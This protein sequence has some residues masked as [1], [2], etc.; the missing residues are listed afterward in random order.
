MSYFHEDNPWIF[1]L[2]YE[3]ICQALCIEEISRK[4][5]LLDEL[6]YTNM[7]QGQSG[8]CYKKKNSNNNSS[9]MTSPSLEH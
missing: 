3:Q 5:S 6:A 9:E 1:Y 8:E 4:G 7:L 2:K